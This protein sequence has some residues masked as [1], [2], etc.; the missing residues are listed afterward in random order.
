MSHT[1]DI[2]AA[3]TLSAVTQSV[4]TGI[5]NP[6]SPRALSV[7]GNAAGITGDVVLTGTDY[8]GGAASETLALDGDKTVFG[9][10]AF[11]TVT[12]IEVPVQTHVGT[13]TV[14][15]GVAD[16]LFTVDEARAHLARGT[17]PLADS[18]VYSDALVARYERTIRA[19]F[20]NAIGVAL[21]PT[22]ATETLNA[23]ATNVL[24]VSRRN[25][26]REHPRRPLTVSA[27]SIDSTALTA[28]EL[29]YLKAHGDGRIIRADGNSWS[30]SSG[31]DDLAVELTYWHG[32]SVVPD[33]IRLAG[34]ELLV[35]MVIGSDV[36]D[37][38]VS[39]SDGGAS[40]SFA[41]PGQAPHWTGV[42]SVDAVLLAYRENTVVIV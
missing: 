32:W 3:I 4:T 12:T 42:D 15:I 34:L 35:H 19:L 11:A 14:S 18:T 2:H 33:E 6:P 13:D 8:A 28:T 37:G 26:A 27:G 24:R 20:E 17:A 41:R 30:G 29:S 39:F 40:Y 5:T 7:T 38:A 31:Y 22:Q 25:P 1:A 9:R 36:P 10:V 23:N 16:A 21:I